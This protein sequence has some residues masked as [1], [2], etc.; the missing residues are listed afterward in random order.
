MPYKP[1]LCGI[2]FFAF[3]T[4]FGQ[5][6][7]LYDITPLLPH[8]R[9][10]FHITAL[11][12]V[13]LNE[14]RDAVNNRMG[15]LGFGLSSGIVLNPFGKEKPSPFLPGID[16]S[17]IWYGVDKIGETSDHPPVKT[18]YNVYTL[19]GNIRALLTQTK[20]FAP[21]IDA[22]LGAKIFNTRTKIDKNL[23]HTVL[24]DDQP[25]VLNTTNDTSLNYGLGAGF[26]IRKQQENNTAPASSAGLVNGSFTVRIL[27]YWGHDIN[28]V[29][30]DSVKITTDNFV[31]YETGR[32]GTDMLVVQ[33]GFMLY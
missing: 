23:L 15:D 27:Y 29:K 18:T 20:K 4:A 5:T 8:D 2:L 6:D 14:L 32:T 12:A 10:H 24:N 31:T 1:S 33:F 11:T 22:S 17:Y 25:E 30:R 21:F 28:Y 13:P 9:V 3:S 26:F 7:S 19:N 16:L